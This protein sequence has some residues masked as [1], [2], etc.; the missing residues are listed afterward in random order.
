[1][2]DTL[3]GTSWMDALPAAVPTPSME[4]L[5]QHHPELVAWEMPPTPR[6]ETA[7]AEGDAA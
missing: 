5:A 3:E 4:L 6:T 2:S 7:E 1:M